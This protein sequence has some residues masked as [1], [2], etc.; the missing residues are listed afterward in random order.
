MTLV[1]T[2][3]LVGVYTRS[4]LINVFDIDLKPLS[5]DGVLFNGRSVVGS[6]IIF[7]VRVVRLQIKN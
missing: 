2:V 4:V 5:I 6:T 7:V 1:L 3:C